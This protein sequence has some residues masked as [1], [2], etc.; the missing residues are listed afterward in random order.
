MALA[1]NSSDEEEKIPNPSFCLSDL[2]CLIF[3]IF[4]FSPN[5][6]LKKELSEEIPS[7][8]PSDLA[9]SDNQKVPEKICLKS[10]Y[11]IF[12]PRRELTQFIKF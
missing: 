3:L 4:T 5:F 9:S 7:I 8:R 2:G 12:L 11:L 10:F 1:I 6:F